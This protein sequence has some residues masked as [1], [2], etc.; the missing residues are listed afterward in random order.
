[1]LTLEVSLLAIFFKQTLIFLHR[2]F[3]I[4][5]LIDQSLHI[6]K[7]NTK[8]KV[9]WVKVST[10]DKINNNAQMKKLKVG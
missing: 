2:L 9:I 7:K 5:T 3:D 4:I 1:M 6:I 8:N 10:Q